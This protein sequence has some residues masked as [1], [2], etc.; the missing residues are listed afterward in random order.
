MLMNNTLLRDRRFW[1]IFWTQF[2][3][4]F[5]DNVFKN[6]LVILIT[7]R[8]FSIRGVS[9][10]Q[11][12]ALCGGIFILPFF[13]F[14]ATAGQ[15]A[16]K[17]SKSRIVVWIKLW[18]ILAMLIG[19]Y[20]FITERF[21]LLLTT[22][23]FMG[24]HSTFFGPVKYSILPQ[25]LRSEE[26]VSG[27]AYVEM[28]TFLAILLGTLLGGF[29]I[30]LAASGAWLVSAA[31][32]TVAIL[33]WMT[34]TRIRPL[35]PVTPSLKIQANP[36]VPTFQIIKLTAK[37]RSVFLS[38]LGISW[39]WFFGA[40]VLSLLPGYCK[41]ILRG[42]EQLITFFLAMFSVGVGVGSMICG[43]LS[44]QKLEL[45]L[46]PVGSLGL[47]LFA[48]DLFLIGN[49]S[50][51]FTHPGA[52]LTI[53]Q[54]LSTVGGWRIAMDLFLL[55]VFGGF[56]IVPLYTLVQQ[57]SAEA[58]RS[59]V[60]AGNNVINAFFMVVAAALLV[61]LLALKFTI[62]QIFL[63]LAVL[64]LAVAVY[65]YTVL[66]EFL[67]RFICWVSANVMYRLRVVGRQHL[68]PD[69]PAVLVCNHVSL[70]DWL[71]I[72]SACPRPVRF[73]MHYSFLQI[74]FTR[75]IFRDAKVIP[76]AGSREKPEILESAFERIA[77]ELEDGELVCIFP[78]GKIT[79]NGSLNKFRPGVE[80]V[81]ATTPVPVVPM[82]LGGLWGSFFSKKDGKPMRRPFRRI[83][84]RISLVIG[85]A[86]PPRE[87]TAEKLQELVSALASRGSQAAGASA[88]TPRSPR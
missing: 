6:A 88:V 31:A 33:G 76:I 57:R 37:V 44:G 62:P 55:A 38:I 32:L 35:A 68:P 54:L 1:P 64:N 59:R 56:F 51:V 21:L 43:R 2:L 29:L 61:S 82:A 13:L 40:A 50:W 36:I 70:V 53:T 74:P 45:G 4:A 78:E 10:E 46:V 58:E 80:R 77:Q 72:A 75:R 5:N 63:L 26:L 71:I 24:L 48:F 86:V 60:I 47:S 79:R 65:I 69:G 22:L 15:L 27:T 25:L 12:V 52:Q 83:W 73:V 16:D 19:A 28:G 67:F 14:S 81:V 49:P 87:A 23:F 84:S 17:Y 18:E 11:I 8:A 30:S 66:P 85:P 42:E 41:Q 3:G 7:L 39:F 20:G 34:S 9:S